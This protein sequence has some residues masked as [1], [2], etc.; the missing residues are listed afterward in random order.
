MGTATTTGT[1]TT[2][3]GAT[4]TGAGTATGTTGWT[5][6]GGQAGPAEPTLKPQPIPFP[7]PPTPMLQASGPALETCMAVDAKVSSRTVDLRVMCRR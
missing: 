5:T 3:V 7:A 2:G 1:I 4:R 6:G